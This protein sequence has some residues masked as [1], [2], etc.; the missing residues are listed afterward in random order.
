M[1]TPGEMEELTETW[2]PYRSL[3]TSSVAWL[4]ITRL[5]VG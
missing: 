1:L 3:G 2:K 4:Y 5:K